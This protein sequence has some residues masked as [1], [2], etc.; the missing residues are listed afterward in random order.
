[1]KEN[2]SRIAV[3]LDRSGSMDSVKDATIDGFNEFIKGPHGAAP[4]PSNQ[5]RFRFYFLSRLVNAPGL[6]DRLLASERLAA[7]MTWRTPCLVGW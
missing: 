3:I 4:T 2:G 7:I 5:G 1:M 6:P